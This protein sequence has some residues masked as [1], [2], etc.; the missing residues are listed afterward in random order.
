MPAAYHRSDYCTK[1]R[2]DPCGDANDRWL[3]ISK[4][5]AA[6]VGNVFSD[7]RTYPRAGA[8]AQGGPDPRVSPAMGLTQSNSQDVCPRYRDRLLRPLQD[9]RLIAKADEGP[10]HR[11]AAA[12][13]DFNLL[14][15]NK[16][17]KVLPIS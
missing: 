2:A 7:P 15:G 5:P 13:C 4:I 17:F 1:Q 3:E 12:R 11:P 14:P 6:L 16:L 8:S 10:L 9:D